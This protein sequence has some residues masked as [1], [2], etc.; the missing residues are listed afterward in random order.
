MGNMKILS[1]AIENI[2]FV[3]IIALIIGVLIFVNKLRKKGKFHS[4]SLGD[5]EFSANAQGAGQDSVAALHR[6][7]H[8]AGLSIDQIKMLDFV[9]QTDEVTDPSES[10]NNS[11]LL[12]RHFKRAYKTILEDTSTKTDVQER[13]ALL[14]S[15]RNILDMGG[16]TSTR[17]LAED[18]DTL[19]KV[20][21]E[22]YP[23]KVLSAKG[24][25]LVVEN[26]PDASGEPVKLNRNST[27]TLSFFADSERAFS[28]GTQVLKIETSDEGSKL[29]LAHTNR[30]QY[31]SN[32]Q[33]R[34]RRTDLSADMYLVHQEEKKFVADKEKLA[35]KIMDISIGGCGIQTNSSIA[36]SSQ[37]KIEFNPNPSLKAAVL[38]QCLRT[39][40]NGT[41]M[42]MH[43]KFLKV[44][45]R[46]LNAINA[47]VFEYSDR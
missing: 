23:S 1:S 34:R 46:S 35:G 40:Q 11:E 10:F 17:Q 7:A 37:L 21:Q 18:T 33:F 4:P 41:N 22:S 25:D 43:I 28:L 24:K 19:I 32:R 29:H 3:I 6:L 42:V 47:L 31:Q 5:S 2:I 8:S 26:P 12:D 20:G 13:L 9:F 15:T 45:L 16:I 30:I 44:P 36:S 14:F 39:N 38:G 27:V